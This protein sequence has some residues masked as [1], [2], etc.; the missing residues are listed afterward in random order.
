MLINPSHMFIALH[1]YAGAF[2]SF[3]LLAFNFAAVL[4]S[5]SWGATD[6]VICLYHTMLSHNNVWAQA[7]EF[8]FQI[9]IATN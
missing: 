2:P 1:F 7:A 9:L 8:P 3:P 6:R 5:A 4:H